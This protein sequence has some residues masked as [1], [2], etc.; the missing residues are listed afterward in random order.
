MKDASAVFTEEQ[1]I[2]L[3]DIERAF[4][5]VPYPGHE[6]ITKVH[7]A[8]CGDE[9]K[10]CADVRKVF[11]GKDWRNYLQ[12]P[13][14]L[15]GYFAPRKPTSKIGRDFLPLLMVQA[16]HYYLPLFLAGMIID[17]READVMLDGIPSHFDPGPKSASSAKDAEL[18]EHRNARCAQLFAAMNEAQRK[19]AADAL[20]FIFRKET[21]DY[22][23]RPSPADAIRNLEAGEII[24]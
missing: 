12:H 20:R 19:A 10:E 7:F 17:P 18:W 16:F 24:S 14:E 9:C 5:P 21:S 11:R 1:R 23:I 3:R 15:L 13:Y 4:A 8:T 6:N 2:L 22:G